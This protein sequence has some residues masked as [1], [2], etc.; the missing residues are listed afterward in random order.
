M[1]EVSLP[2]GG[3]SYAVA[4]RDGG[5]E[6]LR[7]LAS[8]VDAKVEE[9]RAAVGTPS[10]V[11][12]LLFA[13]LLLADEA[14]EAVQGQGSAP[15]APTVPPVPTPDPALAGALTAIAARMESLADALE[16]RSQTS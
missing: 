15:V 16:Q 5:E 12:Q 7:G 13:A 4:C 1:G 2:I 10:E 9:A 3:R 6:H 14:N 8:R 11:R